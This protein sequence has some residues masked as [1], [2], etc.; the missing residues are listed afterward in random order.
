MATPRAQSGRRRSWLVLGL[1]LL[2][3]LCLGLLAGL[4]LAQPAARGALSRWQRLPAPPSPAV[5]IVAGGLGLSNGSW[6]IYIRAADGQNYYCPPY[7]SG[8]CWRPAPPAP[9]VPVSLPCEPPARFSVPAPPGRAVDTLQAQA[10]N[11][12][13]AYQVNFA[14][15]DDGSV[16]RWQHFTSGLAAIATWLL[17]ALGGA[18]VGLLLWAIVAVVAWRRQ[19]RR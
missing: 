17:F 4:A 2:G 11:A 16:W 5:K 19:A 15:L 12:E 6:Y 14:V 18:V 9:N 8:N 1:A 10:C 3:L 13:A 7:S